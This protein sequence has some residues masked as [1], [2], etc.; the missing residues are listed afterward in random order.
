MQRSDCLF[1][2]I[3]QELHSNLSH[4]G[5]RLRGSC[6]SGLGFMVCSA[7]VHQAQRR[8]AIG[9]HDVIGAQHCEALLKSV[10]TLQLP[11]SHVSSSQL[12]LACVAGYRLRTL[13]GSGCSGGT[14]RGTW[15][16]SRKHSDASEKHQTLSTSPAWPADRRN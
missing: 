14:C 5:V 1:M 6:C 4:S 8:T 9:L 10:G 2:S 7:V 12:S 15:Q 11:A 3:C 13:L 16:V